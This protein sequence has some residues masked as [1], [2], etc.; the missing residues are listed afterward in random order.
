M[1]DD[2][3]GF[4]E[5]RAAQ[6]RLAA[7]FSQPR[8]L[9]LHTLIFV[10]TLTAIW[11]Y[12]LVYR[13]WMYRGNF[14]WPTLLGAGWSLILAAH[15]LLHYRRS[16]AMGDRRELAVEDE[17]RQLIEKSEDRIDHESLFATHRSLAAGLERQGRWALAL[18]AFALVNA[19]SWVVSAINIGTSWPFQTTI[20]L[21]L[22]IV[23][24]VNAFSIW[25]Q[26]QHEK[27]DD[28]F[29]RL[30]LRHVIAY[31]AGSI[32]LVLAALL[33]LINPWDA[34]TLV[35]GW[36]MVLL[37]HVVVAVAVWPF[38]R[39]F[40]PDTRHQEQPAKRKPGARLV[41]ADD[42]EMLNAIDGDAERFQAHTS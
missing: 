32:G 15:A 2:Y 11:V 40:L 18:L 14:D 9:M 24:G 7:R 37:V 12:G 29:A 4:L 13:L 31:G 28:W 27:Q 26:R 22:L 10:T 6:R 8:A 1:Q 17:M 3:F 36:G 34:D 30:P 39:R 16:P 5:F 38:V 33:R 23:G 20:P 25:Q 42:G 35:A 21:A 19:V 41:L